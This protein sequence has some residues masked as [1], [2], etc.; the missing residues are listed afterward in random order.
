M[1]GALDTSWPLSCEFLQC[2][3]T[4]VHLQCITHLEHEPSQ[5]VTCPACNAQSLHRGLSP[6]SAL[7][8]VR[9]FSPTHTGPPPVLSGPF[10]GGFARTPRPSYRLQRTSRHFGSTLFLF[11]P[12][13][14]FGV[15]PNSPVCPRGTSS[16]WVF[17]WVCLTSIHDIPALLAQHDL[18]W[19]RVRQS[20]W[21]CVSAFP[22]N[23]WCP[24][25]PP[26]TPV[27]LPPPNDDP[28]HLSRFASLGGLATPL[29]RALGPSHGSSVHWFRW[30][31]PSL[32]RNCE[33]VSLEQSPSKRAQTIFVRWS[34]ICSCNVAIMAK[35]TLEF[36]RTKGCDSFPC[37]VNDQIT[38][39]ISDTVA[40]IHQGGSS[41]VVPSL[42]LLLLAMRLHP[43]HPSPTGL[44]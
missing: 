32:N 35:W 14:H 29:P 2:C 38:A 24:S 22:V 19:D 28:V 21:T 44:Q 26:L 23:T 41:Q 13:C 9:F 18:C 7:C 12:T 30:G 5:S 20:L 8:C 11:S 42:L 34:P 40:Q 17:Q 15:V 10:C 16:A 39:S 31:L 27:P 6:F 43:S 3:D 33:Q 25:P 4:P 37:H 36:C 1:W